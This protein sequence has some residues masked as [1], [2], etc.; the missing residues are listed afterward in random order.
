[1]DLVIIGLFISMHVRDLTRK[2]NP[3]I[4]DMVAFHSQNSGSWI[5][6]V[7]EKTNVNKSNEVCYLDLKVA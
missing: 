5:R 1:M 6:G 7:V 3:K 4:G 2:E